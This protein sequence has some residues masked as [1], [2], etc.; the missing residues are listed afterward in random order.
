MGEAIRIN[1]E[2]VPRY[3]EFVLFP[4]RLNVFHPD[5]KGPIANAAWVAIA[6]LVIAVGVASLLRQ[7]SR[8]SI[9]GLAWFA[10]S[11]L[12]VSNLVVIPSATMAERFLYL[13]AV[14][15]WVIA[16]DQ[17]LR[18]SRRLGRPRAAAAVACLGACLLGARTVARNED[19]KSDVALFGASA[20]QAPGLV[21][22]W[23]NLGTALRDRGDLEG[24]RRAWER[25]LAVDPRDPGALGQLGTL[26]AV[27]GDLPAA[28]A[29]YRAALA[30]KDFDAAVHL[31][32]A[33]VLERT[34]RPGE[35]AQEYGAFLEK[36]TPVH[37]ELVPSARAAVERL[38]RQPAAGP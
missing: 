10:V 19:W 26:A 15:L 37:Q 34:G 38:A 36:A 35:A 2:V 33:K 30:S 24:A 18:L 21:A 6:W 8:P 31:N 11:F 25:A 28:E 12:P 13:P 32:L 22:P 14:G 7:R 27:R 16:A 9:A 23:F 4:Q 20:A 5:M 1:L 17:G 3:L 29:Y